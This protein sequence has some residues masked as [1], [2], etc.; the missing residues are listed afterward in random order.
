MTTNMPQKLLKGVSIKGKS[1][2]SNNPTMQSRIYP[3]APKQ[4]SS[5]DTPNINIY[6]KMGQI[7]KANPQQ[8]SK[9]TAQAT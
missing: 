2:S 9:Q 7:H 8:Q 6:K 5:T 3:L 4:I 1:S